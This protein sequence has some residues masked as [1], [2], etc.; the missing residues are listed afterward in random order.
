MPR[1]AHL[2]PSVAK[3]VGGMG[4]DVAWWVVGFQGKAGG[5]RPP[6][7]GAWATGRGAV[8]GHAS[9]QGEVLDTRLRWGH[10]S[11]LQEGCGWRESRG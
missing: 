8:R 6:A 5:L 4:K 1:A 2:C 7:G 11:P 9:S 10:G 3:C